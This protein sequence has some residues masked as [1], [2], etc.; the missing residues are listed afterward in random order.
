M[1]MTTELDAQVKKI[2]AL[3]TYKALC[4]AITKDGYVP[5]LRVY[6]GDSEDTREAV[7]EVVAALKK[8]GHPVYEGPMTGRRVYPGQKGPYDGF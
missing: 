7:R 8:D 6:E 4:E 2:N 3:K 1:G 5:T